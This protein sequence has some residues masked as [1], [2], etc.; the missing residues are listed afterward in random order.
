MLEKIQ[1]VMRRYGFMLPEQVK[2]V[3]AEIGAE[4]DRLRA[5][6]DQVKKSIQP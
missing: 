5:E 4:V 2:D 1:A 6:L 3:I